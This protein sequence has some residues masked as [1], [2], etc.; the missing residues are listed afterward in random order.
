MEGLGPTLVGSSMQKLLEETSRG[1]RVILQNILH[2]N[3]SIT[4]MSNDVVQ[5]LLKR[6]QEVLVSQG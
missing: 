1:G 2:K 6:S 4:S 3:R 5:M